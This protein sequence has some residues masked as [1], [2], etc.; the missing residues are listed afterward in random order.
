MKGKDEDE[1]KKLQRY[2]LGI[3]LIALTATPEPTLRQGC[4]LLP[5]G[6]TTWK[7]FKATGDES[8]WSPQSIRI[9]DFAVAA[10][11]DFDVS[12]PKDQPLKFD[13]NVLKASIDADTKKKADKKGKK[14]PDTASVKPTE[15]A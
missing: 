12:Q 3:S 5:K 14:K 2:I 10:A 8:D 13:K 15:G 11:K 1:T 6:K 7:Q 4:Q 9:A